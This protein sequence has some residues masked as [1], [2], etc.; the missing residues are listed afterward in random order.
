MIKIY[1]S[2]LVFKYIKSLADREKQLSILTNQM[3]ITPIE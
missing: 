1:D 2:L 3:G